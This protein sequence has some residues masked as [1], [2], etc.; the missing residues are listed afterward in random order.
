MLSLESLNFR[1]TFMLFLLAI[2][3]SIYFYAFL[4]KALDIG[5]LDELALPV[6]GVL[7]ESL[8]IVTVL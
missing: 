1:S 7:I 8:P 4:V 6:M 2:F 3:S 5:C